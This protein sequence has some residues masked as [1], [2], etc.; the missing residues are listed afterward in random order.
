VTIALEIVLHL[1]G[2]KDINRDIHLI[3]LF[4]AIFVRYY[5]IIVLEVAL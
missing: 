1:T 5:K 4:I 2:L 3:A